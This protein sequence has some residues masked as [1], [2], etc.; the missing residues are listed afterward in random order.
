M[1][2]PYRR[3]SGIVTETLD[4]QRF[5]KSRLSGI[6]PGTGP[7]LALNPTQRKQLLR[8]DYDYSIPVDLKPERR[9]T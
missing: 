8:R 1:A 5:I 9:G 4:R 2:I 7:V 3:L 6:I